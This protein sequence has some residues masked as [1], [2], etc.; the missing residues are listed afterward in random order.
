MTNLVYNKFKDQNANT[1]SL[2]IYFHN[3]LNKSYIEAKL[4]VKI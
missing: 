3:L 4:Y 2:V 1:Y